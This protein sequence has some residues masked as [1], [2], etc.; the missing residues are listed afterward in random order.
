MSCPRCSWESVTKDGTTQLG[1]QRFRCSRCGRR[2]TRRSSS[3]FSDRAFAD[4]IIVLA[5]RWYVRYRL[6]YA[7]VSEWLAE[8]G[9][10]VDQ[11]TIYRW[12]Q[13]FLP[14]IGEVARKY[15][16]PVGPDWRVDETY[17]RIRGRWHYI[18]RAIDGH[19]QIVDAYVSQTRDMGAARSFFERAIASS[20]TTPRRVITDKAGAYPP[21][22]G[23]VVPGVLHRTG[24]YRTNGIERD[25]GFLKE[26]LRPMRGLES[27]RVGGHE[28]LALAHFPCCT[29]IGGLRTIGYGSKGELAW[30]ERLAFEEGRRC[31][32]TPGCRDRRSTVVRGAARTVKR[33]R[34]RQRPARTRCPIAGRGTL[35]RARRAMG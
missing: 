12:V 3:A 30:A 10:L 9:I 22:L 26:R 1:G 18:Y 14:L 31:Y 32:R 19:G 2:F 13:R 17:A 21:A 11:S 6:S 35:G 20:G 25:H 16:D 4:D 8:R 28:I 34:G 27:S 5:V 23:V 33:V 29:Q 15:R 7:E 24:R